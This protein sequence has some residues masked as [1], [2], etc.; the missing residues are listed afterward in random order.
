MTNPING[1][2]KS[3]TL[4]GTSS[5]DLIYAK[6]GN[7]TVY[8]NG[9]NDKLHGENGHDY[10]DGG[11]GNDIMYGGDDN[12]GRDTLIG[13]YGSDKLHGQNG[14]DYLDG[15]YGKDTLYGDNDNDTL[16]G[17]F[18]FD[19]LRG[20]SGNDVLDGYIV[21]SVER[22]RLRG[23]LGADTFVLGHIHISNGQRYYGYTHPE[24]WAFIE[25]FD[26][27]QKDKIQVIGSKRDYKLTTNDELEAGLP[28][29]IDTLIW[30]GNDVVAVVV[31]RT[32]TNKISLD[33]DFK[34]I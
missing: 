34:F 16:F 7:D 23:D 18:E 9:G 2:D 11:D 15:G 32:G 19:D 24:S 27:N 1:T 13:G 26:R 3:E 28:G 29:V 20:G 5:N 12:S 22:D 17:G 33:S 21:D 10:L 25:D 6:A 4:R 8:G 30:K 31:D 14:H